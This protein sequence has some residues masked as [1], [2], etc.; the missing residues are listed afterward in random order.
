M[1]D[2]EQTQPIQPEESILKPRVRK[3]PSFTPEQRAAMS[4]RMKKVNADRIAKAR[5]K[6]ENA[7]LEEARKAAEDAKLAKQQELEAE[8]EKLK[9]EAAAAP[10]LAKV[11]KA[12]KPRA[13]KEV[14]ELDALVKKARERQVAPSPEAS[15]S[16]SEDDVPPPPKQT[17][18]R[19]QSVPAVQA[20]KVVAKFL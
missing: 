13:Q 10:K 18:G 11:P 16:E 19:R 5:A 14:A 12:R 4:E 2:L 7:K 1:A 17:R 6:P 9:Q 8:I 3:S 15:D 20:P